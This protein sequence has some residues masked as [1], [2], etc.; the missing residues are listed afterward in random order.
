MSDFNEPAKISDVAAL[1][2]EFANEMD[3]LRKEIDWLREAVSALISQA[4]LLLKDRYGN[5][6]PRHS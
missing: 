4:Q 1:R 3:N 2:A 6:Y 5:P